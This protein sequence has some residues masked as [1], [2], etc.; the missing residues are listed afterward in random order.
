MTL[1]TNAFTAFDSVGKRE[2]LSDMIYDIT[3]LDTPFT[4]GIAKTK[5]TAVR[6]DWQT[7]A[8]PARSATAQLEG[9]TITPSASSATT[10]VSNNTQIAYRSFAVTGTQETVDNAG[11][12]S[13]WAYQTMRNA[14]TL[15]LDMETIN[16]LNNAKV[17]GNT[18][19][20]RELAG[21]PAW[22][23]TNVSA[24]SGATSPTGDGT[25]ARQA[26]TARAFDESQLRSV[27][28]QCWNSGGD[29]DW[30]MLSGTHKQKLSTFTGNATRMKDANDKTLVTSIELY[31]SDFGD[32]QVFPNRYMSAVSATLSDD[33]DIALVLQ[34]DMWA[35]ASL[36]PMFFERLAK[37]GDAE[38]GFVL[39]EWTLECRNEAANGIIADLNQA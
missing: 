24:G 9:D 32:L 37:T 11:R 21:V 31:Q 19:T 39:A 16:L 34:K 29:P 12:A 17:T 1:V 5:A 6:H 3:P 25:D 4:S 22:I 14:E 23:A 15:K 18:T 35:V 26:G 33:V 2:D 13:E 38:R 20:A 36:R 28:R 8:L 30:I 27:V 7:D 10:L